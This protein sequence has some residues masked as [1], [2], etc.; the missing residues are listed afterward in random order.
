MDSIYTLLSAMKGQ[1]RQIDAVANNLANV[2][3][4]GYKSDRVLFREYYNEM[5]GQDLESEEELFAHEE[6]ISPYSRG[7]TS[8][9]K[10]DHVSPSMQQGIFKDT[11]NPLDL[12]LKSEGFFVVDSPYGERFTRN[13]QFYKDAEGYLTTSAGHKVLGKNGPLK[14]EGKEFSVGKDGAVVVDGKEVGFFRI[15]NFD[16]PAR[17]TKLG[18]SYWVPSSTDQKPSIID[19]PVI[20]QGVLEGSNVDSVKE[21]VKMITVNRSYEASQKAMRSVDDLD[22]KSVSIARI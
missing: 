19:R 16:E 14:I 7:G 6:F 4:S 5:I 22:N 11:D 3:T 2:N 15:M 9:V 21:M 12:A 20:H 8:F 18:N 13:G 17:L 10:P 1:E